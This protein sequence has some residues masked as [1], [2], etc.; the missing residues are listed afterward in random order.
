LEN[1]VI[2]IA[3]ATLRD[4]EVLVSVGVTENLDAAPVI[5]FDVLFCALVGSIDRDIAAEL[6]GIRGA[7]QPKAS[8]DRQPRASSL[9]V[10]VVESALP[11]I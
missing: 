7:W 5:V 2:A 10:F 9:T 4:I 1:A 3:A 8:A 11:A 6:N